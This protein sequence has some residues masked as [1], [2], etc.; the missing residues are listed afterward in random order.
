MTS[1]YLDVRSL[2]SSSR[3]PGSAG[4]TSACDGF[5]AE[6]RYMR[7]PEGRYL[8]RWRIMHEFARRPNYSVAPR[9]QT[10]PTDGNFTVASPPTLH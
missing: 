7:S 2:R 8:E 10:A 6:P 9:G 3:K 5:V 1:R 4:T